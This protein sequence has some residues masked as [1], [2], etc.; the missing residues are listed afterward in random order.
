MEI[1]QLSTFCTVVESGSLTAASRR[2]GYAQSTVTAQ[3]QALEGSVGAPLFERAGRRVALTHAGREAYDRACVV[4]RGVDDLRGALAEIREGTSGE[5]RLG[6]IESAANTRLPGPVAAFLR[7]KPRVSVRFEIG[8]TSALAS[9][10]ASG[11]LDLIVGAMPAAELG[12]T[13]EPLYVDR[14]ALLVPKTSR[15]FGRASAKMSDVAA[16]RILLTSATCSYNAT[17]REAATRAGVE[18]DVALESANIPT[19]VRA[20][21]LG[22]GAAVLPATQVET[23]PPKTSVVRI[24]DGRLRVAIGLVRARRP[25]SAAVRAFASALRAALRALP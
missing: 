13:F 14:L 8:G 21:Q 20:V 23:V 16:E 25:E 12:L 24:E 10:L 3:L 5:V 17:L 19:I 18:L 4:L 7:A 2:L 6:A 22:M 9:R 1:R 15:L 11:E